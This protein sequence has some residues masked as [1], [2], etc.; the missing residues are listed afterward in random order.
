MIGYHYTSARNWEVIQQE[1]LKPY[2]VQSLSE[3]APMFDV[4]EVLGV[5]VYT[6]KQRGLSHLGCI[7]WQAV[8]KKTEKVTLLRVSYPKARVLAHAKAGEIVTAH[9]LDWRGFVFH[10]NTPVRV[11]LCEIPPKNIRLVNMYDIS[12]FADLYDRKAV[13]N[14]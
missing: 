2:R 4:P 3:F 12:T 6:R 8:T 11:V 13:G 1:G 5:W 10:R 14:G 7:L 9:D